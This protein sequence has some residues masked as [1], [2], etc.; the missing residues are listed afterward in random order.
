MLP[1]EKKGEYSG[2]SHI[3]INVSSIGSQCGVALNEL[4]SRPDLNDFFIVYFGLFRISRPS[5]AHGIDIAELI[6]SISATT[7]TKFVLDPRV[8]SKV[9]IIGFDVD[10]I[11]FDTLEKILWVHG[12]VAI[13][14]NGIVY[15]LP[16]AVSKAFKELLGVD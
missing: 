16:S 12:Y 13:E 6:G 8:N 4:N 11:D 7:G 1:V 2:E 14:S 5:T 10:K 9:K 15:V 3:W